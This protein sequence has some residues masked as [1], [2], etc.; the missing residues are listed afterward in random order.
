MKKYLIPIVTVFAAILTVSASPRNSDPVVMTVNG[1]EIK[2]SEFEYLYKKNNLQQAA[3][4]SIDD[5]VDMFVVYKL[6]VADA[7]VAG[8]DTT[9]AFRDEFNGYCAEL[10][11]PYL[12]DSLVEQRLVAEAYDRMHRERCVSHILLPYGKTLAEREANRA[13][14]DSIRSVIMDGADFGEMAIKY[15]YDRSAARNFGNMGYIRSGMLPYPFEKVAYDTPVG[16]ISPVFEDAPYGF[17]IIK[18]TDERQVEGDVSA[19]H[20]LKLTKGL[21][22]D[23]AAA[24]KAQIDSIAT[25]LK[26]GAD[27]ED[28]ARRESEDPG[29]AIRGG[30]LGFFGRGMMVPEFEQ[31][32]FSLKPG[33]MSEPFSTAY[34]Y[35]IVQT[36]ERKPLPTLNEFRS[37]ILE[38]MSRDERSVLPQ[39]EFLS[40]VRAEHGID[41]SSDAM[42][43]VRSIVDGS[44]DR[45]AAL[46]A[47]RVSPL[48][49][50]EFPSRKLK[51]S[52]VVERMPELPGVDLGILFSYYVDECI[53]DE[54]IELAK[55]RL[56]ET[57]TDYRNLV[58]EYRDGILLFEISNRNVWERSSVDVEAQNSFFRQNRTA[59]S[60]DL[61]HFKGYVI[62]ATS[63]SVASEIQGF[64]AKNPIN[65]DML[66]VSLEDRF[67]ADVKVEHILAAKGENKIIDNIAFGGA[68]VSPEGKWVAWF[69]YAYKIIDAPEE[70]SD[71]KSVLASDLQQQ[72]EADWVKSLRSKYKVKI[73]RKAIRKFVSK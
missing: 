72:L 45:S 49:L 61:P 21:S 43:A 22:P 4:L 47:L 42:N 24:K 66:S 50:A 73:N 36:L 59:Y 2:L 9:K 62:S 35:H 46:K 63:D 58:N 31:A 15:S 26:N 10:S 17:H 48:V 7:E 71:I 6:K 32:A 3:P 11:A 12:R 67:G 64:L 51:V 14:L 54:T 53:D 57:N 65:K 70:A 27:F 30:N 20:I 23:D 60:W 29:S 5:Y 38:M 56:A 52:D 68:E 1:K 39:K 44:H 18:V 33:E 16:E 34:G 28:L 19:R 41:V 37:H 13:R 8:I 55:A 25:L 40:K 69:P